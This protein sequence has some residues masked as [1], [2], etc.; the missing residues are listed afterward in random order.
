MRTMDLIEPGFRP[1]YE[2]ICVGN[3]GE[4]AQT[5]FFEGHLLEE[6]LGT[7]CLLD[8]VLIKISRLFTLTLRRG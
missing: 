8:K 4:D 1:F 6:G 2:E 3:K 7:F 5:I